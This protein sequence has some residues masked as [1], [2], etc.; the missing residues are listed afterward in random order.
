M[1]S[2][3]FPKLD[4]TTFAARECPRGVHHFLS[5]LEARQVF[6]EARVSP[7]FEQSRIL[8]EG[9]SIYKTAAHDHLFDAWMND[10]I[11][12]EELVARYSEKRI[13][14]SIRGYVIH[15]AFP[16]NGPKYRGME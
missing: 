4:A 6:E 13:N 10:D 15:A 12:D 1:L 11:T 7:T 5:Y 8:T 9:R 2:R 3:A 14:I 16:Q